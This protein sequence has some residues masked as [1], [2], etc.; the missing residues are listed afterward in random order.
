MFCLINQSMHDELVW[1]R[2]GAS[3]CVAKTKKV[4]RRAASV[5][6]AGVCA[7]VLCSLIA[8]EGESNSCGVNRPRV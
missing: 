3:R 6:C 2:A 5:H 1:A 8:V 4:E 7:C